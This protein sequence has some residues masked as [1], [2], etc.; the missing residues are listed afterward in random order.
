MIEEEDSDGIIRTQS[1]N[2]ASLLKI[3]SVKIIY[4][5]NSY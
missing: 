5:W 2:N 4:L 3:S 1:N